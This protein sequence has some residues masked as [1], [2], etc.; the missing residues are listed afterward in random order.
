M[1]TRSP[2]ASG[3]TLIELAIVIALVGLAGAFLLNITGGMRD[4]NN[5]RNVRTTLD[6][7]DI[8]LAN[9][10]AANQRLPCPADGAVASG[11]AS[12]GIEQVAANGACNAAILARGVVPWVTLGMSENDATDPW[13]ARL[14]YRVDPVL[15][16]T[17]APRLM[18]MSRCDPA[19][20][21]P[22]GSAGECVA[23]VASCTGS[24]ACTAPSNFLANKGLDV[25]DGQNGTTGFNQRHNSRAGGTGAA[26]VVIS[27]GPNGIRAYNSTGILQQ[28]SMPAHPQNEAPNFNNQAV[29]LAATEANVYRD[30]PPNE[31]P[32]LQPT[33]PGPPPPPQT[34]FYADDYVSHPSIMT[35]LGKANLGPRAH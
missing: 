35:V 6:T 13:L 2:R 3:F 7:V 31:N 20:T 32:V 10:V 9:F 21:G 23:S 26:Y 30:A 34:R 25:W 15:A 14:T 5:R 24:A 1:F 17:T 12:A 28:G 22:V 8:A 11:A 29:V 4:A 19:A 16:R 18:N 27:H 33:P